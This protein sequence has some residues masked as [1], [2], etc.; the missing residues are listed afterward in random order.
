MTLLTP[1][2]KEGYVFIGAFALVSLFLFLIWVPLGWLGILLTIWC[3]FFFRDPER[4]VPN[5]SG[6]WVAPADGVVCAIDE[7]PLPKEIGR[8]SEKLRKRVSIFM[9]VFNC[10]IN[11][12]PFSGKV[13]HIDYVPGS[14]LNASLDKASENNERQY[15][16]LRAKDGQDFVVVQIAGLVA[17]RI[18]LWTKMGEELKIGE[19]LGMIRFGSRVDIY[20]PEGVEPLVLIGQKTIGGETVIA[21]TS[22]TALS[23]VAASNAAPESDGM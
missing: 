18:V 4:I 23:N 11:R 1:I 22:D 16:T 14:F 19:R 2:H 9:D 6:V 20:L 8:G 12:A 13:E 21:D 7:V 3:A 5:R 10:H 17:R 15:I